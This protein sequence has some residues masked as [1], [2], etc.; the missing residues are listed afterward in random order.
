MVWYGV[1]YDMV[2]VGSV[3]YQLIELEILSPLCTLGSSPTNGSG[4]LFQSYGALL[5][6]NLLLPIC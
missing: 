5:L 6:F 3:W 2:E 1:W 4:Q